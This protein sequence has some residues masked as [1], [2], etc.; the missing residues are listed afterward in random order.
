MCRF[1]ILKSLL[2]E[3]F[4]VVSLFNYQGSACF[5][6]LLYSLAQLL[7][8]ITLP[9][10]CQQL[11][12][13]V[14]YALFNKIPYTYCT[15]SY[16][17]SFALSDFDIIPFRSSIVNYKNTFFYKK[18]RRIFSGIFNILI[19]TIYSVLFS[20]LPHVFDLCLNIT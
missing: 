15:F 5:S 4:K 1:L 11:F 6:L 2:I 20:T 10:A 7:Y 8:F 16:F 19:T 18:F 13:K 3:S 12:Q 9:S 17:L 14:L